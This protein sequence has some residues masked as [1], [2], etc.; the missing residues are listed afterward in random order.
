MKPFVHTI[1]SLW[2]IANMHSEFQ[3][4]PSQTRKMKKTVVVCTLWGE[5]DAPIPKKMFFPLYFP[6][7][8]ILQAV[9]KG[10]YMYTEIYYVIN[11]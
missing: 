4:D 8:R 5:R 11:Y 9:L 7:W 10:M 6:T 1:W 2:R 3:L